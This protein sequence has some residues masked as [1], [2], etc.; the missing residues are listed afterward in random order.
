VDATELAARAGPSI[1]TLGGAFMLDDATTAR[2]AELGLDL[3]GFY[4]LGRGSVLGDV[5]PDVVAA[6]FPFVP[7]EV[8]CAVWRSARGVLAPADAVG[9]Y[10]EACRDWGRT[11]LVGA[12]GLERLCEL[13]ERV[14]DAGS[15]TSNPLFAGWRAIALP[16]DPAGRAA[17]LLFVAREQRGGPHVVAVLAS[18]LTPLEAVIASGGPDGAALYGW[19]EPYPDAAALAERHTDAVRL[20]DR[21]V[22]PAYAALDER[23]GATLLAVL[24]ELGAATTGGRHRRPSSS[25]PAR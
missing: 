18:D 8:V 24:D 1:V 12:T 15:V 11:H 5:A 9:H 3:A 16:D 14:I 6:S 4:G 23:E 22:A 25:T 17:Q 19:P 2:G 7:G 13:L 21:L 10:V 20:T